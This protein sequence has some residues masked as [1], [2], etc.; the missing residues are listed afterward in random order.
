VLLAAAPQLKVLVSSRA[1]LRIG[2]EHAYAVPPLAL[3]DTANLPLPAELA[4]VG[5][6]AL[7]L[8]RP[9]TCASACNHRSQ[10]ERYRQ[11]L[12]LSCSIPRLR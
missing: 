3:P 9:R 7:F 11:H 6:G 10:C 1:L 2:G 5:A 4:A 8:A 12:Q